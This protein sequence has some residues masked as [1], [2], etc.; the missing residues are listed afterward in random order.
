MIRLI[1]LI[2][3]IIFT[4]SIAHSARKIILPPMGFMSVHGANTCSNP[5]HSTDPNSCMQV[6]PCVAA[7]LGGNEILEEG[8][9]AVVHGYVLRVSNNSS[10][11]Q[12]VRVTWKIDNLTYKKST[13]GKMYSDQVAFSGG[14]PQIQ[15]SK[16]INPNGTTIFALRVNCYGSTCQAESAIDTTM[17]KE[18]FSS[19]EP[20]T[21]KEL[22]SL[23]SVEIAVE[24]D[25][26][27]IT[28]YLTSGAHRSHGI[29]DHLFTP[30]PNFPV[31]G[32]RPF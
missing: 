4:S 29:R 18:F 1:A 11:K 21:C 12:T 15:E 23:I 6:T 28:A 9:R 10:I 5:A 7:G 26:G 22:A 8:V 25:A 27:A 14:L 24:E 19:Q 16:V 30:L 32:G 3:W 17:S 13:T 20:N 31:N 2:C